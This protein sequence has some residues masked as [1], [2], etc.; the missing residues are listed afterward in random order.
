MLV[1]GNML[2]A[3]GNA[4]TKVAFKNYAPFEECRTEINGTFADAYV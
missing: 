4:N 2:V 1:T 3:V